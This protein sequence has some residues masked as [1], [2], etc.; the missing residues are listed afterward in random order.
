MHPP[1]SHQRQ[2]IFGKIVR[3]VMQ[4]GKLWRESTPYYPDALQEMWEYCLLNLD[5]PQN[6]YRPDVC[7]VITW[8]DDRLK[9]ILR[10]HRDRKHRQLNRQAFP[11]RFDNGQVFDPIESLI[12]PPDS[13]PALNMWTELLDW[14][15]QDPERQL[16]SRTCPK[17]PQIN[18]Q[19]LLLHRLPPNQKSWDSIAQATGANKTYIAQWYSRHCNSFLRNWAME[20]GYLDGDDP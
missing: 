16:R 19:Q 13:Q 12:S 14:I 5:D 10:R 2:V 17:Y 7:E 15:T 11:K 4:S 8:L 9:K 20:K 3:L 1:G 18:A 6:G